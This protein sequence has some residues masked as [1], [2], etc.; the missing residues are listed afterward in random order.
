MPKNRR[1]P[2]PKPR[3]QETLR[4]VYIS[5]IEI[6]TA[7]I[8]DRRYKRLPRS[9]KDAIERLHFESQNQPHKVIPEL[10]EW[11][12]KYPRIPM[13]YNYLGVAYMMSGQNEKAEQVVRDNYRRNPNYSFARLNYAQLFLAKGDY[14]KVAE[15]LDHKFDLTLLYPGRKRFHISEAANFLGIVGL[16]H[17]GTGQRDAAKV[18]YRVLK[19]IA[20]GYPITRQFRQALH[21]GLL[22]R[23][24]RRLAAWAASDSEEKAANDDSTAQEAQ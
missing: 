13:L 12:D 11:I 21:P 10:L 17:L 15:I 8:E 24:L 18:C 3:E 16:Y 4:P 7:P 2:K 19:Q 22:R 20:P 14:E 1:K 6:T 9:V 5:D 23:L